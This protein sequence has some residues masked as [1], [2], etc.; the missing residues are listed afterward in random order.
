LRLK[1]C[2]QRDW[3]QEPVGARLR[4]LHRRPDRGRAIAR[5]RPDP[6]PIEFEYLWVWL[7]RHA[8][9]NYCPNT[10]TELHRGAR[11]KL[12]SAQRRLSIITACWP[13]ADLF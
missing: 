8:L 5:L 4:Q 10:Q 7:K 6:N 13:Q 11:D 3:Q 1:Q 12:K 9:A 2:R